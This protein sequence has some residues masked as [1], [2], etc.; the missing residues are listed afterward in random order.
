[1]ESKIEVRR[2]YKLMR[3]RLG[4]QEREELSDRVSRRV[5]EYLLEKPYLHHVHVFLPISHLNEIDTLPLIEIL[6]R[7]NKT[8]YTSV[9]NLETKEMTTVQ[10]IRNQ[11]LS[12]GKYGIPV[13]SIKQSADES[14]IQLVLIPLLAYDLTGHRL[15]YGMGF[16]DRFLSRLSGEVVKA[17]LSFFPPEDQIP[18]EPHDVLLDLCI[19]PEETIVF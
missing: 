3:T 2:K 14:L 16:Y 15:G 6:H 9:S 17:G 7:K 5:A 4:I 1:M 19:N 11:G 8:V 18:T 10:L 12:L 13:P